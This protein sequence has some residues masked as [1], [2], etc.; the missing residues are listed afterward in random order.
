MTRLRIS[1][2]GALS[3]KADTVIVRF[4]RFRAGVV[5]SISL[6]VADGLWLLQL[7]LHPGGVEAAA[8]RTV[9]TLT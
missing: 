4:V 1:I 7:L 5:P 9:Q 3:F 6:P 2:I 8:V